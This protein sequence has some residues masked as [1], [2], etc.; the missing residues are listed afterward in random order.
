MPLYLVQHGKAL[1]KEDH[2]DPSLSEVGIVET[3][4]IAQVAAGYRINAN[5]IHHSG[6]SRAR[7]T[8]EIFAEAL[9][10]ANGIKEIEG[11][12]PMDDATAIAP[13]L[14]PEEDLMLV[15]HLPFMSR[16]TAYLITGRI[17]PQVFK[18][19]NSGIVCL[20]MLPEGKNWAILWS[21]MPLIP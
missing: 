20:D 8:A 2:P 12:N 6:K 1:P 19:Q 9:S 15:G 4:R 13:G 17:E 16:L 7:Q 11:I 3:R 18:F 10:P 5:C 14:K 21:L